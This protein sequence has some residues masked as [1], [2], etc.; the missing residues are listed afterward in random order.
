MNKKYP[1][2]LIALDIESTDIS[3]EKGEIIEVAAIKYRR[4]EE[5][6]KF[7]TLVKPS[8]KI[9]PVVRSITN[10]TDEMVADAPSF[11]EIKDKLADFIDDFPVVGHNIAFDAAFLRA[12]G[13]PLEKN[14]LYD[15][16]RLVTILYQGMRSFSLEA[17]TARLGLKHEEKHRAEADAA[18]GQ[19]LFYH[20][21]DKIRGLD[22]VVLQAINDFLDRQD[23]SLKEVFR[24]AVELGPAE[25]GSGRDA[26]TNSHDKQKNGSAEFATDKLAYMLGKN[27]SVVKKVSGYE[28]RPPQVEMLKYIAEAFTNSEFRLIEAPPG[29]GK[30]MAYLLPAITFARAKNEQ[31]IV[32]T[33]TRS[34]QD[35][36]VQKDIPTIAEIVPFPFK[37]AVLKG[38]QQYLC[39]RLFEQMRQRADLTEDQI[40]T[41]VKLMVW[42]HRTASGEFDELALTFEDKP[43]VRRL[44]ADHHTC[45]GRSC[46]HWKYCFVN[47]ARRR[48]Q[49]ADLVIVNH[50]LLLREPKVESEP[51]LTG[52]HLILDEAHELEDAATDA[53]SHALTKEMI[54]EWLSSLSNRRR[55]GGL[56]DVFPRRKFAK[57]LPDVARYQQDI[58]LLGNDIALFFGLVGMFAKRF[59]E[60]SKYLTYEVSLNKELRYQPEWQRLEE[61]ADNLVGKLES[62]CQSLGKLAED[63]KTTAGKSDKKT[64][65]WC[66]DILA[67]G[68]SGKHVQ[69]LLREMF[70]EPQADHVYWVT[71]RRNEQFILKAAPL[72]I[73]ERLQSEL[74]QEKK[75]IVMTSAT[76]STAQANETGQIEASFDYFKDRLG[77]ADFKFSRVANVFD[78]KKQALIYIPGDIERPESPKYTDSLAEVT[79]DVA[80]KLGG[81]TLVLFTSYAGIKKVYK[82]IAEPLRQKKVD[83]LA[84]GV[85]G[86]KMKLLQQFKASER[87]VLLGTATFWQGIDIPGEKLSCL[88]MAKLPF[89][90]PT[91]PVFKARQEEYSN[92][93]TDYAVPLAILRFRQGFGRLIRSKK[94]RGVMII[95]DNRVE[96]ANYGLMFMQ[97]LPESEVRYGD[98]AEASEATAAWLKK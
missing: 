11:S 57:H 56:L 68:Q 89:S 86:G 52:R 15:T 64:R 62:L 66:H 90:V 88:I 33:Y 27:G 76:L 59:Q 23:W 77:L 55:K 19:A 36:L 34:L 21:V 48:A 50:A 61:T 14:P 79:K 53:Y 63:V 98:L 41:L 42:E 92:G 70:L 67:L 43:T 71:V 20:L 96:K 69:E 74:Y 54:D 12:N 13:I 4:G 39:R 9:P 17:V 65:E 83:V 47:T 28:Y 85:T 73:D 16:W 49:A 1:P 93:F 2:T 5:V 44:A 31:V 8:K 82:K 10:I 38:R 35:Q 95:M 91:E 25:P 29:V 80:E 40:T 45:Q 46:P 75:V 72:R 7:Q 24:T 58:A 51:V 94:D 81:R 6:D 37:A 3:P 22:P 30:S 60:N 18:A 97:S 84:Q 32:S 87:A 78:Y 26:K